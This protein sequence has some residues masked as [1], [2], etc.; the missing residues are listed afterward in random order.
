[1][2]FTKS[3]LFIIK[4]KLSLN[5]K[6]GKTVTFLMIAAVRVTRC[7]WCLSSVRSSSCFRCVQRE[8]NVGVGPVLLKPSGSTV[9]A[10]TGRR[11]AQ[12]RWRT[13]RAPS[14]M[15]VH[16]RSHTRE[17]PYV[18]R[19]GGTEPGEYLMTHWEEPN[20]EKTWT[21]KRPDDSLRRTE[22]GKD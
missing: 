16:Q 1:M 12:R 8:T 4:S 14:L 19:F 17:K 15:K 5:H 22:P 13:F 10:V 3:Q 18:C 21:R 11:E 9:S 7:F 20:Q 6:F 2:N